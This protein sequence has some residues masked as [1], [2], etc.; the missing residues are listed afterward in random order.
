MRVCLRVSTDAQNLAGQQA[1]VAER[2]WRFITSRQSIV[3]SVRRQADRPEFLR[4]VENVRP[5]EVVMAE[6]IDA[7]GGCRWL[8]QKADCRG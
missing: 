1:I 4:M 2:G 7:L 8:N 5:G 3:K 6:K